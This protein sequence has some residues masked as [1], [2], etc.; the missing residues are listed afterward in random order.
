MR[1]QASVHFGIGVAIFA[2]IVAGIVNIPFNAM[3]M[4][5]GS[6]A[7]H[8]GLAP[9]QIGQLG[10]AML[11]GWVG[12][13]ALCFFILHRLS[14][15]LVAAAG[16]VTAVAGVQLSV[17][18]PDISLGYLSWFILGFGASLP[19]CVCFEVIGNTGNQERSFGM[20][21]LSIVLAS[22]AVLY[23]FPLFLLSRWGYSGLVL[24]LS[25]LFLA[26]LAIVWKLPSGPLS[27]TAAQAHATAAGSNAP[28]W[29][30]FIAFLIFFSG[31]SGLWAFLE[32]AGRE[33]AIAPESIGLILAILK[34]VGGLASITAM[35]VATRFGNRW[36]FVA[37]FVGT[38][39]A[40]VILENSRSS[41]PYAIGGWIWEYFF[42]L[43]FCYTTAA[44]SRLDRSGRVVVLLP[45][46]IGLA[47]ALG[48]TVAGYMKTG[49]G[50]LPIYIFAAAC[51]FVC[52]CI[53]LSLLSR[54][55]PL[56]ATATA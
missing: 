27:A 33:I 24:G 54:N 10:G 7:D 49:P 21:T 41:A 15:R 9:A 46:A 42:T 22:A 39:I 40:V 6:A 36:P 30:A 1:A 28:A 31:Q 19:T 17:H 3:P 18:S 12:G 47:G 35:V 14:W 50:F 32:R 45:G 56:V 2:S 16:L 51:M 5:L 52:M 25:A 53:L 38:V 20:M 13:T 26:Q 43:V 37:G 23:L 8:Y 29:I 34:V 48:P 55:K 4:I 44:I 11:F